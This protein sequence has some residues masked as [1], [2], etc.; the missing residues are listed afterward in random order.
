MATSGGGECLASKVPLTNKTVA[1][2]LCEGLDVLGQSTGHADA[3]ADGQIARG[4]WAGRLAR[5]YDLPLVQ[6]RLQGLQ[7][8]QDLLEHWCRRIL[9]RRLQ[10]V[11]ELLEGR[12]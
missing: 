9:R 8:V 3:A 4:A 12:A 11:E 10:R 6:G 7:A 2:L 1:P 5:P